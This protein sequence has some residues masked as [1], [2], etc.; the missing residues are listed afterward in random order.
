M[1]QNLCRM[2][3]YWL[4]PGPG[5][6]TW[7]T[8]QLTNAASERPPYLQDLNKVLISIE[9]INIKVQ[10]VNY[11][12]KCSCNGEKAEMLFL[13]AVRASLYCLSPSEM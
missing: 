1:K 7:K 13:S 10:K 2:K 11:A 9:Y 5:L 8:N 4:T 3:P 6:A 12:T